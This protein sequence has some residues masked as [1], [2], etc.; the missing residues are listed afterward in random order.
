[1]VKGARMLLACLV[2]SS[3]GCAAVRD[4]LYG[5]MATHYTG[6]GTTSYDKE[7][8]IQQRVEAWSDYKAP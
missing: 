1:M 7:R 8:D 3:T 5:S 6:G 2:V 4:T